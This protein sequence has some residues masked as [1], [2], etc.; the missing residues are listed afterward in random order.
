MV[1]SCIALVLFLLSNLYMIYSWISSS[2]SPAGCWFQV[3]RS[4]S[5]PPECHI[6]RIRF[7]IPGC[8]RQVWYQ[9]YSCQ[10]RHKVSTSRLP[11]VWRRAP[12]AQHILFGNCKY[13][14]VPLLPVTV[15]WNVEW[16]CRVVQAARFK[17]ICQSPSG[18]R[19]RKDEEERRAWA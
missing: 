1:C 4:Q 3:R 16:S 19:A 14:R 11:P 7:Q 10:T 8:R 17:G 9:R 12:E 15:S 13:V 5:F 6:L 18:T 2:S